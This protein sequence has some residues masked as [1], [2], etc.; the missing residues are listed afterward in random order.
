MF[1]NIYLRLRKIYDSTCK[2]Y[3]SIIIEHPYVSI[4]C[5]FLLIIIFGF[6]LFQF[7]FNIDNESL[8]HVRNSL[9]RTNANYLKKIFPQNQYQRY[10]QHQLTDLG[11]SLIDKK[12]CF[13]II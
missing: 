3:A 10:F 9:V 11:K 12:N 13:Y 7:K 5:Y 6:G 2:F 8:T 4:V 1:R